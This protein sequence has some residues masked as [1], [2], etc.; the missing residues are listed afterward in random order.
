MAKYA[1]KKRTKGP[2]LKEGD[3]VYLLRRNFKTTRPS[4]KLDFKKLGPFKIDKVVSPVNYRLLLPD[5][6]Q[7]YPTFHVSLLEP[8]PQSVPLDDSIT[9]LQD[10]YEVDKILKYSQKTKKYLVRWKGYGPKD[11]TWEPRSHLQRSP[12]A[13]RNFQQAQETRDSTRS[14]GRQHPH[15]LDPSPVEQRNQTQ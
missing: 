13:L 11:D 9:V 8:A 10:E 14:K 15:P 12:E 1:N 7:M 6:M 4:E 2:V 5:T 3:H